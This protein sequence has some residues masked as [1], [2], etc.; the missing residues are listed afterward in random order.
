M[1]VKGLKEIEMLNVRRM[2]VKHFSGVPLLLRKQN[3]LKF[4]HI[5]L[6][7][8]NIFVDLM[9]LIKDMSP[10]EDNYVQAIQNHIL[11]KSAQGFGDRYDQAK[12]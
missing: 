10:P 7:H 8:L 1:A 12:E 3:Q 5:L 2:V 11:D 6:H 9:K 4:E